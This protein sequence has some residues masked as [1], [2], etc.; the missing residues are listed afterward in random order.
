VAARPNESPK[1]GPKKP[2]GKAP[3]R[4]QLKDDPAGYDR[5]VLPGLEDT[6]GLPAAAIPWEPTEPVRWWVDRRTTAKAAKFSLMFGSELMLTADGLPAFHRL[7]READ[8]LNG[9]PLSLPTSQPQPTKQP[10]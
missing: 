3:R 10:N 9:L 7:V 8:F 1:A 4:K 5:E 6:R 2:S